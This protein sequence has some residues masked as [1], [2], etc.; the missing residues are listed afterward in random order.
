MTPAL[1]IA[2]YLLFWAISGFLVLPFGVRTSREAGEHQVPGEADS[3]PANPMMRQKLLWTTI[4]ATLLFA[5]FY[6]NFVHGWI[7]LS[8]IPG[9][10]DSG[11]YR[12]G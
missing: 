2:T 12:P 4:I 9:W 3:A 7:L 1:A 6:A 10:K 5:L 11:P 8:D